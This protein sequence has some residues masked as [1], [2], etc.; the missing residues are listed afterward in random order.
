MTRVPRIVLQGATLTP[1]RKSELNGLPCHV[2]WLDL[3]FDWRIA[4]CLPSCLLRLSCFL[5]N[6]RSQTLYKSTPF[7]VEQLVMLGQEEE[8]ER[9]ILL[10]E[11]P[12]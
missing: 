10:M 2:K 4:W 7:R 6:D 12:L 11:Y 8:E 5:S 9:V 3:I 1:P